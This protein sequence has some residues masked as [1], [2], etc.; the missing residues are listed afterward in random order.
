MKVFEDF[1]FLKRSGRDSG[2]GDIWCFECGE[3]FVF[4]RYYKRE[5]FFESLDFLGLRLLISCFF[6]I[7]LRGGC[8]GFESDIDLEFI[9]KM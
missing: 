3:F 9:F 5:D 6:D 7:M 2:Y 8:E 1:S 4:L